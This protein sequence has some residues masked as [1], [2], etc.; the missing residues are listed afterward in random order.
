MSIFGPRDIVRI[1]A[2]FRVLVYAYSFRNRA[3]FIVFSWK[4]EGINTRAIDTHCKITV[5]LKYRLHVR[6]NH[7]IAS[8]C[9][10][11]GKFIFNFSP[12]LSL[13]YR[14]ERSRC[15]RERCICFFSYYVSF[16]LRA[17]DEITSLS[18]L[19]FAIM[20]NT[21]EETTMKQR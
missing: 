7:S 10:V 4:I 18:H 9:Y 11:V 8:V 20:Y 16:F 3:R 14:K 2:I 13:L 15:R 21:S 5:E 19:H 6:I 12:L 1:N 17:N